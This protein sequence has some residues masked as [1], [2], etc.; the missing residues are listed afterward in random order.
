MNVL[1]LGSSGF[2]GRKLLARLVQ[3]G[4]INNKDSEPIQVITCAD[5][6]VVEPPD[7]PGNDDSTSTPVRAV[8][9]DITD[10]ESIQALLENR[11]SVIFHLA[12]VVSGQAEK[13]FVRNR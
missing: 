8:Q 5:T 11:P 2:V 4:K 6:V 10:P 13:D 1:I 3:D 9:V 7:L 12:A